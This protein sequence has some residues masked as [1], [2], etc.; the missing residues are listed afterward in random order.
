MNTIRDLAI[1]AIGGAAAMSVLIYQTQQAVKRKTAEGGI[2]DSCTKSKDCSRTGDPGGPRSGPILNSRKNVVGCD[3][4]RN[5][6]VWRRLKKGTRRWRINTHENWLKGY[7][8]MSKEEED[9]RARHNLE[10]Q[11][12]DFYQ[13]APEGNDSVPVIHIAG[14]EG[15]DNTVTPAAYELGS[16]TQDLLHSESTANVLQDK[17]DD[18]KPTGG[19]LAPHLVRPPAGTMYRPNLPLENAGV[20]DTIS[21]YVSSAVDYVTPSSNSEEEEVAKETTSYEDVINS[22]RPKTHSGLYGYYNYG[23]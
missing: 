11:Q 2:G 10:D 13:E 22:L 19:G 15:Q 4:A 1:I 17:I 12:F 14:S 8:I 9:W 3:L 21:D 5:Q 18:L 20:V 16:N 7:R 6:C 23:F